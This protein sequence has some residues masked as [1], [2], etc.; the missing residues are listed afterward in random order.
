MLRTHDG[1]GA[2]PEARDA[3]RVGRSGSRT[4]RSR[5]PD[6]AWQ[7]H[8]ARG[9]GVVPQAPARAYTPAHDR[10]L[11]P[12]NRARDHGG[13]L[14]VLESL[15]APDAGQPVARRGRHA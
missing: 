2:R 10:P 7:F 6:F 9:T 5:G 14:R 4:A 3:A 13:V 8:I 1:R 12:R 15:A 11:A